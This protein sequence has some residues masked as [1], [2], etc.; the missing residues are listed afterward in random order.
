MP[1]LETAGSRLFYQKSGSGRPV[2]M[3]HGSACTGGQWRGLINGLGEGFTFYTP[4][5][6]GYGQS[7]CDMLN[8]VATLRDEANFLA[9]LLWEAN[10]P[11]DVIAHSFGGAVALALACIWPEQVRSLT[12]YEPVPFSLLRGGNADDRAALEEVAR[13]AREIRWFTE[14]GAPEFAM[15]RFVDYWN[16]NGSWQRMTADARAHLRQFAG[17]VVGNFQAVFQENWKYAALRQLRMPTTILVGEESPSVPLRVSGV[18]SRLLPQ[19]ELMA[20]PGAGHMAPVTQPELVVPLIRDCL[21]PATG[22]APGLASEFERSSRRAATTSAN[23]EG[24]GS[25]AIH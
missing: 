19:A 18:L 6:P 17:M 9:P 5:L 15:L 13:V 20:V 10:R 4:D 2:L 8:G 24:E 22:D 23:L 16:G 25:L 14:E 7:R 3:I 11:V 1:V 21:L 12:L